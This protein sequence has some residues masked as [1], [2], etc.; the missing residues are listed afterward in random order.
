MCI[1]GAQR[2]DYVTPH[3]GSANGATRVMIQG[4]GFAQERQFQLNPKDDTFGNRV[5]LV[6]NTLSVPCDVE[7]DSTHGSRIT[8]VTRAMP[9]GRYSVRVSVDGVPI[10][11]IL[12][13]VF[14][15]HSNFSQSVWFRTPTMNSLSPSS[16]PPGTR[17]VTI[18]GRIFTNVYGSNTEKSSNGL[19]VRFLRYEGKRVYFQNVHVTVKH[20][21][22]L[23]SLPA[24]KLFRV[25][26]LGKLSMFQTFAEVTGVSPA[27]GS[28]MGGTLLTIHG[29]YFDQT[30]R[31]ARV[32]VGGLPCEIQTVSDDRITCRT[33]KHEMNNDNMTVYPG[34][35]GLKMEVWNETRPRYLT[36]ILS[37]NESTTGYWTEWIDSMPHVFLLELEYFTSRSR[38]F[39]VPPASANYTMYLHC[40]DRCELYLSNSSRPEDKVKHTKYVTDF[41]R[42]ESQKSAVLDLKQG[43]PYYMEIL[44]QE[45]GNLASL[46]VALFQEESPFTEDQT[47][48]AVNEVQN[49]VAKYDV[50]DEEQVVT[51]DS[52][53][54]DVTAVKEVQKVTVSSGCASHL[55]SSFYFFLGPIPVTASADVVEAS[56]NGLWTIKPD[57]VQVTKQDDSRGSNYL[58]TFNSDRGDFKPLHWEVFGSDTNVTVAEVTKGISN[59]KTFT[60][61]WGGI[62]TKPI[63]F[64]ATESEVRSA[65]EDTMKAECPAEVL[66]S[67]TDVQYFNDFEGDNSQFDSAEE[68]TP[69]KNTAFCG[70]WSLKNAEVLFKHTYTKVSG[71]S[72]GPVSLD[73]YPTLCFAY[74]GMLK[75]EV[76][77][78]FTYRDSQGQ[79]Q[80]ETAK[81]STLFTK[82]Q[83]SVHFISR[84]CA[85]FSAKSQLLNVVVSWQMELQMH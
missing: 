64:N 22:S 82:G 52:W 15:S 47:D 31:P 17:L 67:G 83:K 35:R 44:H 43:T 33:A 20:S 61:L 71:G 70:S 39:F 48:D 65:L 9:Y 2:V 53:P 45:Y 63:A 49:I 68:G 14:F 26:A 19:N 30:D 79:T 38:G 24:K 46:N 7:R 59:M 85:N 54:S 5:F 78:K 13:L 10:P 41:T 27:A 60:L 72:Y 57:T 55:F 11:D 69:M 74:K 32:L 18:R 3:R 42:M 8:C 50:F 77:M 81:I 73:K 1:A 4:S 66:T 37:Y 62:P 16:G 76:G 6:S 28:V 29:R 12:T 34:G 75:D 23:K 21:V 51:F 40:D 36:D 56:L 58:V 25:S 80:S 84:L